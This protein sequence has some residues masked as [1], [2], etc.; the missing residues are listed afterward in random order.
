[1]KREM[2][3][4]INRIVL[5]VLYRG[6]RV[7]YQKDSRV[8]A[9]MGSWAEGLSLKLVCGPGGAVLAVRKDEQHGLCR[10]SRAQHT[11]ITMRFKTVTGAFRVLSG[12][13]G[14]SEAYARHL[15]S[16]EGDIYQ[17]MSFVR[18]VEYLEAYLFPEFMSRRDP[19]GGSTK[20]AW[21]ASDICAGDAGTCLSDQD[22]D[23][24]NEEKDMTGYF[25]FANPTRLCAGK[26]AIGNLAYELKMLQ[27]MRPMILSDA[28]LA[29]IGTLHMVLEALREVRI[30]RIFTDIPRDSS[31]ET[32]NRIAQEY[33]DYGCD[34]IVAVGGGSVLDTAKGVRLLISQGD[35]NLLDLMGCECL[36][37][38]THIPFV[39]I[40]TTAGTGSEAT[41]VA[42]IRNP[43]LNIKMEYISQ[44]LMPDVAILDPKMTK[45]LPPR[46]TASTGMDTLCHAI[47][48]FSCLQKNPLSDAYA[49]QAIELVRDYLLKA[50]CHGYSKEARLAMANASFLAGAAFSNSM[51]G[52]V[53]AI[54][55]ALGGVCHVAHGDAMTILLPTGMLFNRKVCKK[56]YAKLLL[57]L[58][59]P[60]IYVK[61]PEEKR[62][63]RAIH[64][65]LALR[66]RLHRLT[67]LPVTLKEAGVDPA[68]FPEVAKVALNDGAV[69]VNPRQ[70][71]YDAVIRI[72]EVCY[73]D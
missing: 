5:N 10:L 44:Q 12:Q 59:G 4:Q 69:I 33:R 65:V 34:G 63:D 67:G 17:T 3:N 21:N 11:D 8:C 58:A 73:G 16:L 45:T 53:H 50:V 30:G 56:E 23:T 71:T 48:A 46:I 42:V 32:V 25:E 51:V 15:F 24:R 54:G 6:L 2:M 64:E 22:S 66:N 43:E 38:E 49:A 39:A 52:V 60:E 27:V 61:T 68:S 26:G 7:L 28:V 70:V 72:L 20:T 31:I 29:K 1:M 57:Y 19:A 37:K 13:I 9:E 14:I 55:H 18:C 36:T 35:D 40:P 62:A 41:S 47:E